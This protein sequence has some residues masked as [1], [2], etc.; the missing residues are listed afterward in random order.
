[1]VLASTCV[2]PVGGEPT[3][4]LRI[5]ARRF[6]GED[7]RFAVG[8]LCRLCISV[9]EIP[10]DRI[11]VGSKLRIEGLCRRDSHGIVQAAARSGRVPTLECMT[12]LDRCTRRGGRCGIRL[13]RRGDAGFAINRATICACIPLD[14]QTDRCTAVVADTICVGISVVCIFFARIAAGRASL[15]SAMLRFIVFRPAS[16]RIAMVRVIVGRCVAGRAGFC[17]AMLCVR[18]LAPRAC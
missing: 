1:M 18:I 3:K 7:E 12:G 5:F 16:I 15:C 8:L 6:G 17:S 9:T 10:C 4:E 13:A 11:A 14:R 2:P